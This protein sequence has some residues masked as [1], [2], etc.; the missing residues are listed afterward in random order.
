MESKKAIRP[1]QISALSGVMAVL[2][3]AFGA[4]GLENIL[5]QNQT[6]EIWE[7]AVFYHFIHTVM[8][9]LLA[10]HSP[11]QRGPWIAFLIGILIFSGS[12]YLLALTNIKW[13]GAITPLGGLSFIIAW[14][15]CL[16][17][18]SDKVTR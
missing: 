3:G 16:F 7:T 1:I 15:W 5:A 14:I 12:L 2:L 6:L 18:R 17:P 13:L 4:H 11:F 9:F 8:M 10:H